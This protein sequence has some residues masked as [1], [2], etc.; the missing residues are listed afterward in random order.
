MAMDDIVAFMPQGYFV[1]QLS[2]AAY[3]LLLALPGYAL[4]RRFLPAALE[5]GGLGVIALSYLASF[6]LLAP[7]SIL[8]Y[9]SQLG[10][11]SMSVAIVLAVLAAAIYLVR[12]RA[13]LRFARPSALA[14]ICSAIVAVDALF[15]LRSGSNFGGDGRYHAGRVRM[16]ID[17]G[18]NNWD[19]LVAGQR[20]DAVYHTNLYHALIAASAQ[21]TRIDAHAAWAFAWFFAKIACA[22]ATYRLTW[23]LLGERW[24]AWIAAAMFALW[25]A[26]NSILT[27]PNM[28]APCWLLALA[29]AFVVDLVRTGG[30]R[31]ALCGLAAAAFT[32][33]QV[34]AL[35]YVFACLCFA[36]V[37]GWLLLRARAS[38]DARRIW[39]SALAVLALG[40]PWLGV[41]LW[42]RAHPAASAAQAAPA[43]AHPA[44][45]D[46]QHLPWD[47]VE[48]VQAREHR[49]RGFVQIGA[50]LTM[51]DPYKLID[52][53]DHPLHLVLMLA[54][55]FFF[56]R[57]RRRELG[58][59][60]AIA[61]ASFAFMFVP[62]LCVLLIKVLG[63]PWMVGRMRAVSGVLHTALCPGVLALALSQRVTRAWVPYL[64]L[65]LALVH[66]YVNGTDAKS[67]TR[68][69]YVARAVRGKPLY[70]ALH[71]AA[72]R[73]GMF[74]RN[75]P[76]LATVVAPPKSNAPIIVDCDCY[77][78]VLGVEEPSRGV[79]DKDQRMVDVQVLLD[80]QA[81][82]QKRVALLRYYG[83]HYLFVRGYQNAMDL[84]RA[85]R[86]WLVRMD[87]YHKDYL[88]VVDASAPQVK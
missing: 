86:P 21:L 39:A 74:D 51:V 72:Q 32:L 43:R 44:P 56:T 54:I 63:A 82:A 41:T 26:S 57:E 33:P 36:P 31:W 75:V 11:A 40:S 55:G 83:L 50:G 76:A 2:V 38:R 52:P 85:Y 27:Y 61:A 42:Q 81:D 80:P 45:L 49:D 79:L 67:W 68:A 12:E 60:A 58:V 3:W 73:R 5:G 65:A 13:S 20:F 62:P 70:D 22:A 29:A 15:G 18:F 30:A 28:L 4:L 19:P 34:H 53:G 10:L 9:A 64:S 84:Q 24:I 14:V 16:L 88:L 17:H 77:P 37:L 71:G 46:P 69:D 78:F 6:T 87:R 66:A 1:V 59:A 25:N 7:V 23:S 35:Y 48:I 8:G 47:P